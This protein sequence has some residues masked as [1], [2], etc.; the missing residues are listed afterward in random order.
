ME[1][2]LAKFG[3]ILGGGAHPMKER[4]IDIFEKRKKKKRAE[5]WKGL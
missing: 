5:V 1:Q 2:L 3:G 4:A